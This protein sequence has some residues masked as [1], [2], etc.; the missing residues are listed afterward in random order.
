MSRFIRPTVL[1]TIAAAT[2]LPLPPRAAA[3]TRTVETPSVSASAEPARARGGLVSLD[4]RQPQG[5]LRK[6][7][8]EFTPKGTDFE[9]VAGFVQNRLLS[10]NSG[11]PL[12]GSRPVRLTT[13][14]PDAAEPSVRRKRIAAFLGFR[15]RQLESSTRTAFAAYYAFDESNRLSDVFVVQDEEFLIP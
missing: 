1:C 7:L 11:L 5:Y 9:K 13:F 6:Q 3:G 2:L 8:L 15:H 14:A 4:L 12:T 10:T